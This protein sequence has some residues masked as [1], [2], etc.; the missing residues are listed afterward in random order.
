MNSIKISFK[1]VYMPYNYK[2]TGGKQTRKK[3]GSPTLFKM[4]S[5]TTKT[6]KSINLQEVLYS[7][8][9]C[10]N[11]TELINTIKVVKSL[12]EGSTGHALKLCGDYNCEYPISV[13]FSKVSKKMAF[14]SRH[15]V[16][17][18]MKVQKVVNKLVQQDISP[19]FNKTYGESII[20][21]ASDLLKIKYFVKYFKEHSDSNDKSGKNLFKDVD[22][23][24]VS[25]ME[26]GDSDL[27]EYLI[28]NCESISLSEMKAIL[29][30]VFYSLMC[31][32]YHEPGFKHL[33]LK[34]DNILVF[35]TNKKE[36]K[37]KFN[38]YIVGDKVFYLPADMIQVKI[39]D[40]DFAVSN[41]IDNG[42]ISCDVFPKIGLS[43]DNNPI[44]DIHYLVNF[45]LHFRS[46]F[47][48]YKKP[49]KD[50]LKSLI[51]SELRGKDGKGDSPVVKYRLSNYYVKDDEEC[52]YLPKKGTMMTPAE[53]IIDSNIFS[54][55]SKL[56]K[57][58]EKHVL[59]TYDSKISEGDLSAIRKRKDMYLV[60]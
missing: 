4:S 34:T 42:K 2:L 38:K 5:V 19:H 15:P 31:A 58:K 6:K 49:V 44:Q 22:K 30:Q 18:E 11:M 52:N 59:N 54:E 20:C 29:F 17:V 25:F 60:K 13:K 48:N 16:K 37:G 8:I 26:L 50:F 41:K 28:K 36:T 53:T 43:R 7:N 10:S 51:P 14:N 1:I 33:D 45:M 9:K 35:N 57:F 56:E 21:N 47:F 27:F 40:F 23:V 12:G 46:E 32:Q 24:V 55:F 3:S 39:F